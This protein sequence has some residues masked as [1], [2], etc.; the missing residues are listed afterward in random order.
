MNGRFVILGNRQSRRIELFQAAL[1]RLA[2]PPAVVVAWAELLAGH[3]RLDEIIVA[4]DVVR[5]ESPGKDFAVERALLS[6]GA[7]EP[8]EEDPTGLAYDRM[9]RSAAA[10]LIFDKG[11]IHTPRQWYLGFRA[12]LREVAGQL[13]RSATPVAAAGCDGRRHC[14]LSPVSEGEG[15]HAD[16]RGEHRHF[17]ISPSPQPSPLITGEREPE[18]PAF[19]MA[20]AAHRMMNCPHD[21]EIMF[22]KCRCHARLAAAG[23]AVPRGITAGPIRCFDELSAAM[24]SN[25]VRRVFVKLA[26]GSSASGVVAYQVNP[27]GRQRA[28][29]TVEM[30][31]QGGELVLYNSR[32]LCTYDDP[33]QIAELID[34]LARHRVHV[35][36][37]IPKAGIDGRTLDLRVLVIAGQVRH[38]VA[39]MSRSPL[40]NLHLLNERA[41]ETRVRRRMGEQAWHAAMASC[42]RAMACFP[43]SLHGG[44]DLLISADFRLHAVL[45]V[46]A[47]GDLLPGALWHGMDSYE[48]EIKAMTGHPMASTTLAT[49]VA[50]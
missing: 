32:R 13:S 23:V 18:S 36:Q 5:L 12:A 44:V 39:R 11:R 25:G 20:P 19:S 38:C 15:W 31:R 2:Q 7:D 1:Q 40:T 37:W 16:R 47:F 30:V 26:H 48:A 21:V 29:T 22:D 10:A 45:E 14:S 6:L 34:A 49:E 8:D 28:I 4:G 41:N 24:R 43:Q 3:A 27:D 35:E 17:P 42:E 46:N 50:S 9:P 33:R